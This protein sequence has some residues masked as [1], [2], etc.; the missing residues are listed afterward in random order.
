MLL[1]AKLLTKRGH[2]KNIVRQGKVRG[3]QNPDQMLEAGLDTTTTNLVFD[4]N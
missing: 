1:F 3:K 2:E 4:V